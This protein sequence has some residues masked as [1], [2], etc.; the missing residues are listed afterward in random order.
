[1]L[2]FRQQTEALEDGEIGKMIEV[3]NTRSELLVQ[4]NIAAVLRVKV[5]L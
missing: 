1:M 4:A 2:Q 3:H 5:Y